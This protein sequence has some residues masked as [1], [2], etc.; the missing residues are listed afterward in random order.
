[1][2]TQAGWLIQMGGET[3]QG[4]GL[5][6][7]HKPSAPR[8]FFHQGLHPVRAAKRGELG[9]DNSLSYPNRIQSVY[10]GL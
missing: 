7:T 6:N 1:M 3:P 8:L 9:P 5:Y 10:K 2:V 4:S